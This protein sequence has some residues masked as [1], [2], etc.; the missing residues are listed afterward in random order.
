MSRPPLRAESMYLSKFYYSSEKH[1]S[2]WQVDDKKAQ[3]ATLPAVLFPLLAFGEQTSNSPGKSLR[4]STI[5]P[6]TH[7]IA[8][9]HRAATTPTKHRRTERGT[10]KHSSCPDLRDSA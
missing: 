4:K 8:L 2:R 9:P 10:K 5:L 1:S 6:H 7:A 3:L